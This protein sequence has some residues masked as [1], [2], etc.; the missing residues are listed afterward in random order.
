MVRKKSKPVESGYALFDV[1]YEDGS[2]SS[3]RRV[4]RSV[5]D[6]LDGDEPARRVIEEQDN[7]IAER[8]GRPRIPI[9]KISRSLV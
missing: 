3:N 2:R 8:A 5:L 9:E 6:G 1:L 4:P 7:A